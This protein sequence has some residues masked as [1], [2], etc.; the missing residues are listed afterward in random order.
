MWNGPGWGERPAGGRA[1]GQTDRQACRVGAREFGWRDLEGM[2][3][4]DKIL[5]NG[6]FLKLK[7][8]FEYDNLMRRESPKGYLRAKPTRTVGSCFLRCFFGGGGRLCP[9]Y[10]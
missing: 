1:D 8:C 9:A 6:H 4:E 2:V 3:S 10:M 7:K 5:F